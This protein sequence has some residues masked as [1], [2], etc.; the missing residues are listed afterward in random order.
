MAESSQEK[1]ARH[2][3]S[4]SKSGEGYVLINE[5]SECVCYCDSLE[6]IEEILDGEEV[7]I[8]FSSGV[9]CGKT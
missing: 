1:A 2:G 9:S 4:I 7:L 3:Y 8:A 5:Y 6:E